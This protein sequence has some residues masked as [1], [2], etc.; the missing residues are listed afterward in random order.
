MS[1]GTI[2]VTELHAKHA[3]GESLDII[4]VRTPGEFHSV[5]ATVARNIPL[6]ALDPQQ[7]MGQRNGDAHQPLYLICRSGGR[8]EMAC[9]KFVEQGFANVVS[10]EGGTAAWEKHG[11][12]VNRGKRMIS[13]DRQMRIVAGALVC[14]GAGLSYWYPGGIA[15]SAIIGAGLVFA[16]VTDYCPM[17]NTI[18]RMPWNRGP[19]C[20]PCN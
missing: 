6:G 3:A 16:G 13:V 1:F 2:R 5:H 11:L 17:L 4:D 9:R 14:I 20:E 10:V 18:A 8:S 19:A 12:P 7:V 15:L